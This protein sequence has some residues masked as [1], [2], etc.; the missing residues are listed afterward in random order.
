MEGLNCSLEKKIPKPKEIKPHPDLMTVP[1]PYREDPL[2][3]V[4]EANREIKIFTK[5][6]GGK[7]ILWTMNEN[8]RLVPKLH[9]HRGWRE[10]SDGTR[11]RVRY[12]QDFTWATPEEYAHIRA[13]RNP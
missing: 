7:Q 5:E 2:A 10:R 9:V 12:Y 4:L 8:E 11:E 3:R 13:R 1:L 6:M